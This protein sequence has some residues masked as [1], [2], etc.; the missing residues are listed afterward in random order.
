MYVPP[1]FIP[2][3]LCAVKRAEAPQITCFASGPRDDFNL[4]L[5][6]PNPTLFYFSKPRVHFLKGSERP[7]RDEMMTDVSMLII[8]EEE[9]QRRTAYLLHKPQKTG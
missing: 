1:N 6:T 8:K 5:P 2:K 7:F 9:A 4:G 3:E